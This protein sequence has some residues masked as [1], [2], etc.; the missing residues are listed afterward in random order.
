MYAGAKGDLLK[1]QNG[2]MI[3]FTV[4]GKFG[5]HVVV[6]YGDD[7]LLREVSYMG[8]EMRHQQIQ[9]LQ[10]YLPVVYDGGF[11]EF[12][13]VSRLTFVEERYEVT[14]DMLWNGYDLKVHKKRAEDTWQR[15]SK[16]DRVKAVMGVRLYNRYLQRTGVSKAHPDTYLR[17]RYYENEWDKVG[18]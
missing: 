1:R 15:M 8:S 6:V 5:G 9:W 16:A 14:F 18:R 13:N 10:Q 3:K 4:T 17:E 11:K 12:V 2:V 7:Y